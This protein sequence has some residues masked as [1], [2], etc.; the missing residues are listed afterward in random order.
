MGKFNLFETNLNS[1]TQEAL[2][3]LM[4][5]R[6]TGGPLTMK[7]L[8]DFK[9]YMLPLDNFALQATFGVRGLRGRTI[10]EIIGAEGIGKTTLLLTIVGELMRLNQA[11]ALI[12]N[13]EGD[14]KLPNTARMLR[15]LSSNREEAKRMLDFIHIDSGRELR[16][17]TVFVEDYIKTTRE[18]LN[19]AGGEHVPIVVG[20]DTLSKLM[21]PGEAAGFAIDTGDKVQPKALGTSSNLEFSKLMHSWCRRLPW[22]L[23]TYNVLMIGVSHQNIKIN[24]SGFG[25]GSMMSEAVASGYN[26]NKYGGKAVDQNA[27]L[28]VT[29]KRIGFHKNTAGDTVGH[30]I[31]MRVVKSSIGADNN[32]LNYVLKTKDFEDTETTQGR[33]LDFDEGLATLLVESGVGDITVT[34]KRYSSKSLDFAGLTASE[35]AAFFREHPEHYIPYAKALDIDGYLHEEVPVDVPVLKAE[36]PAPVKKRTKKS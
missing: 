20:I 16:S 30:K 18:K 10:L 9:S 19:A 4:A 33:A 5:K 29:L 13:T 25:G 2:S 6:K 31:E 28:Q 7:S 15:A 14:N 11:P 26:K 35:L 32:T 1:E 8:A 3:E 12:V 27:A 34:R 24:M 23:D 17:V 21:S 36:K 22:L